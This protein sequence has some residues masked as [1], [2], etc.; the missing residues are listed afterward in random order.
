MYKKLQTKIV[1]LLALLLMGAGSAWAEEATY[2]LTPNKEST[3]SSSTSYITTLTEFTYDGISWKMNQWNPSTLQIKTNQSSA[4]SE[5]RFYNTSAFAGRIKSV[6]ITFSALTVSDASKLMFL[7]GSSEVTATTGGTAGTWNSTAK[8]LTWTPGASDNFTYFAFYQNGKAAS[9]TNYLAETNAIVVTYETSG[10]GTP[11]PTVATPTFSPAAGEVNYGQSVTISQTSAYLIQYTTDGSE[12]TWDNGKDIDSNPITITRDVTIKARAFDSNQ[13]ASDVVTAVYTV[14]RPDAPTFNPAAGAVEEGTTV[15]ISGCPTGG[16]IIYTTDGTNPSYSGN[17]GTVYVDGDVI[18][19]NQAMTIKAIAVDAHDFESSVASAS[20]TIYDPNAPGTQNNPYTVAQAIENTPSSGTSDNV[21]IQGIVSSFYKNDIVSDG[22]NYRYYISDDGTTE[23]ELLV[24]KGK[25]LNQATFT[26]AEDLMVGDRVIIYGGLTTYNNTKE[27]AANNYI[28]S[29]QRKQVA[30][31]ALSGTYPTTFVEGSTFSHEGIVVTATYDDNSTEDVTERA[32]FSE[33]NMTQVG[34]QTVTVTYLDKTATYTINITALPTHTATFSVEGLTSTQD[35]KEG[36]AIVFPNVSNRNGFTFVGWVTSTIN[37]TQST[38][39]EMV[40]NATMGNAD[41]TYYAVFAKGSS[42]SEP[43]SATISYAT[44]GVPTSYGDANTFTEY[45]LTGIKFMIQ[46][47]YKN[48]EK[49]QWRANGNSNGTG[50]M[51]N[52]DAINK[53][54]SIVL[55][56]DSGDNNKNFT[57]NVGNEQNPTSGTSITPTSN[58]NVY[59]FDCSAN[60]AS[61][62]VLTNGEYAGYLTSIVINYLH[63]TSNFSNYC[64]TIPTPTITVADATLNVDAAEH[65]GT[66]AI[67]YQNLDVTGMHCMKCVA[68][69]KD[70]TGMS[71]FDIQYYDSNNNEL[72]ANP[73]WIMVEVAE[74]DPQVGEGYVVSYYMEENIMTDPRSVYFKVYALDGDANEVYSNLVT[75]T[76]AAASTATITLYAAC[77]DGTLID[78]TYYSD[79]AYVMNDMLEGQVVSVDADGKLVV[80]TA[81][82]G[83]EV[84]P[85]YTALLIATADEFT[86]TKEYTIT[87]STGGDDWS[88]FNMLKGTLTADEMTTGDNCLFYRLTMHNGTQ[89]GFWW[90]AEYGGAFKPGANKAYLAVPTETASKMQGFTFGNDGDATEIVLNALKGEQNGE[91]YNL[92]GQ[93]VGSEYKGIVIVNG[94]KVMVK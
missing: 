10:G 71:D 31:I 48:G 30:S 29:L 54:Q 87:L 72:D 67:T 57:V 75:I 7:G 3:S 35:F 58:E 76:Q 32:T 86:G 91:M 83:G 55:T 81:Y 65:E 40:T 20:Y 19:I 66:M 4:A 49:L 92:Q 38:A 8:T 80:E 23:N 90:G 61:Y 45:T 47:M 27:I 79:K 24:Y 18:T 2:S 82:E 62:F 5:F 28:V 39:P 74:Q 77:T 15:T 73:S 63:E 16:K 36:A 13:N 6:V 26:N 43:A 1:A 64:T 59:T 21:Y 12:P 84:V 70:V 52:V 94:K 85:A 37:G 17:I 93:K 25:G 46:Q 34:E 9:G 78:G 60:N 22:S 50:T 89:I 68:R 41:I 14:K 33:P 88:E 11:T 53:I 69:V 51:Y 42:S 44:E 56:Y